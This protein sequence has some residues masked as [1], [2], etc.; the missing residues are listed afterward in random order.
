MNAG[1][2][3]KIALLKRDKTQTWLAEAIGVT[4]Q[5]VSYLCNNESMSTKTMCMAA[6]ALDYTPSEFITL[7]D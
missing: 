3:L 2:C 1:K 6:E 7:S 4:H 5:Q